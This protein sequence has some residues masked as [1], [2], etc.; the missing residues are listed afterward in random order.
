MTKKLKLYITAAL[1]GISPIG[2]LAQKNVIKVDTT[3]EP[4]ATGKF[5]ANWNSL[6]QYEAPEWFQNA[7]FGIW[8][9]WGPQCQP[10][11]GDW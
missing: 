7:K 10:G 4:V 9:H 1:F 2:L 3:R 6:Q 11:Q 8:A 5:E